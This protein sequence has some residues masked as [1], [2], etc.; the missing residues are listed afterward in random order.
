MFADKQKL[1][2]TNLEGKT[3][4]I[5]FARGGP[6]GSKMPLSNG[7]GYQCSLA[8]F[9][10]KILENASILYIWVTPEES[11]RKNEERCDPNNPGSILHHGVGIEVMLKDY[12]CDDVQWLAQQSDMPN[13]IAVTAEAIFLKLFTCHLLYSI[14]E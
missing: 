7:Y 4:V 5:E 12:G 8:K 13:T 14:I 1:Q 9:D 3:I 6:Q 11:R 2:A 10:Q